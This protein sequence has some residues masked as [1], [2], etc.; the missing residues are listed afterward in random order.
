[1]LR[2]KKDTRDYTKRHERRLINRIASQT[3]DTA[4]D[5]AR[6]RPC[7]AAWNSNEKTV[8]KDISED[9]RSPPF[10]IQNKLHDEQNILQS[11]GTKSKKDINCY[12]TEHLCMDIQSNDEQKSS[13]E[14]Y[15]LIK[16]NDVNICGDI[17]TWA[18]NNG[19]SHSS[20]ENLLKLLRHPNRFPQLPAKAK[21]LF[22]N[23][24][25]GETRY[26]EPGYYW[27]N[28]LKAC[29]NKL[30]EENYWDESV[31]TLLLS[32]NID[33]LP[34]FKSSGSCVYPILGSIFCSERIFL[35][36][37]Y[38]GYK[39]PQDFNNFLQ[40]FVD[41]TKD[42]ITTG[43]NYQGKTIKIEIYNLIC[44][45]LAK[46]AVLNVVSHTG[47]YS[48]TKCTV[49]GNSKLNRVYFTN[50]QAIL[51]SNRDFLMQTQKEH[52]RDY[53]MAKELKQ[54]VICLFDIGL[55]LVPKL[56]F[57][58]DSLESVLFPSYKTEM[59]IMKAIKNKEIPQN[60]DFWEVHQVKRIMGSDEDF[61]KAWDKLK[62]ACYF[63]EISSEEIDIEKTKRKERAKRV[64]SDFIV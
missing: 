53:M 29:L 21:T 50:T 3:L 33:G 15:S 2:H 62:K 55:H 45:A 43:Y 12:T 9:N 47:Y 59:R 48:C 5:E 17:A 27:H 4:F 49:K 52:H 14:S 34:L 25:N 22:G 42:L 37:C 1:M 10:Q 32:I 40:D 20:L 19:I 41:K 11:T 60:N 13:E 36:G 57:M 58:P 7:I 16:S 23:P 51:R 31:E 46:A 56:W 64:D 54:F 26:V 6:K 61:A 18:V 39:K 63:S 8:E 35:I 30:A 28:G 38:H 44:D 24:I